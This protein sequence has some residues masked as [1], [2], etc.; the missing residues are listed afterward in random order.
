MLSSFI[1]SSNTTDELSTPLSIFDH[2]LHGKSK[3]NTL[4]TQLKKPYHDI[5]LE[6]MVLSPKPPLITF[7]NIDNL[8]I[9]TIW[10]MLSDLPMT[11]QIHV[12]IFLTLL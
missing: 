2:E 5:S 3:M 9:T 11:A 10:L 7:A 6:S 1:L 8:T 12:T 4:L